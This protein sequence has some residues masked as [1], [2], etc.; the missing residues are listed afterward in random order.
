MSREASDRNWPLEG[1]RDYLHLL[2]RV[3]LDARLR[4]LVDSSDVVQQTLLRAHER[5]GQFRGACESELLAWLRAILARQ[6]ADL[7]RRAGQPHRVWRQSLEAA[8]EQSSARLASWL[9]DEQP[10]PG[11]Q[12]QRREQ[13]LHLTEALAR[14]P[15]DQRTA[16][17]LHHLEG[18]CRFSRDGSSL[19]TL[20]LNAIK[21][22]D[23][24]TGEYRFPIRGASSDLA[25]TPDG[26]RIAAGS[27]A[28]TTSPVAV[29]FWDAK[30][31]QGALISTTKE[32]VYHAH[33]SA[34]GRR[35]IYHDAILDASTGAVVQTFPSRKSEDVSLVG[36]L[37]DGKHAIFCRYKS[38]PRARTR[39][40]G[41]LI[42]WDVDAA[43]ELRRLEGIPGPHDLDVS[44]DGRWLLTLQPQ[45]G[46]DS[47]TRSELTVRD[48]T[49]WEPVLT[50]KDPPVYGQAVF[51]SDSKSI[52]LGKEDRVA[53]IEVSSGRERT[54]YGPLPSRPTAVA[55][56]PDARWVAAA[57]WEVGERDATIHVW[58]AA[59]GAEA[60]VIPR[61]RARRSGPSRSAPTG[62]GWRRRDTTPRSRS[63]T[64][65]A[66]SSS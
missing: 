50:R 26:G 1:D 45:E 28:S 12:A 37:P 24:A 36:L 19:A 25:F 62:V 60:H 46:D 39:P 8:L 9:A 44:P 61:P 57:L 43:R 16:V 4:A 30:R 58:D 10:S 51:S 48:A 63:G 53:L 27:E 56:S 38:D 11:E 55:L 22:W 64:P 31:E 32:P 3:G 41:D 21:L 42:L 15:E 34:D 29:R 20:G 6:M 47:R 33:F 14:L 65:R 5:I 2:S 52:L 35:V 23:G 40:T 18:Y 49:T 13:L 7:A 59:S 66:A 17:E 54:T